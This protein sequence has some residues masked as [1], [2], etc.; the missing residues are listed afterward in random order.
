MKVLACIKPVPDKESRL[1]IRED[2]TWIKDADLSF[3]ISECDLYA[4]EEA[5]RIKEKHGGEVIVLSLGDDPAN[6]IL[7]TGLAMGADRAI[8]LKDDA[9]RGSDAFAVAKIIARAVQKE[10]G[11][12]VVLVG[13]Q[14]DDLGAGQ[15]GVV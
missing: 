6:K 9:F 13:L 1:V 14:S 15:T 11:V 12:D 8:Q 3:E 7:K 10:G 4:L 2:Q 5:L